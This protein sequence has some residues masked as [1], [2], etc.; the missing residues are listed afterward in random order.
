MVGL[1]VLDLLL[2]AIILTFHLPNHVGRESDEDEHGQ[3]L[4]RE[5]PP[6]VI[7]R[8]IVFGMNERLVTNQCHDV[9]TMSQSVASDA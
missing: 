7:S 2:H 8:A 1:D 5:P 4:A 3:R 6:I 9:S